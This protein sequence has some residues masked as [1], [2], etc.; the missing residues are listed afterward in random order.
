MTLSTDVYILDAVPAAE[1]FAFAA[2]LLGERPDG[3]PYEWADEVDNYWGDNPDGRRIMGRPDQG[4]PAWLTVH[5]KAGGVPLA[6]AADEAVC[7]E[8]CDV[9]GHCGH[10]HESWVT[11]NWDTAYGYSDAEGRNCTTLHAHYIVELVGWLALRGARVR[12]RNEY[13]N[14]VHDGADWKALAGFVGDGDRAQAW[15][16]T[17]AVPAILAMGG[18][19]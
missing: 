3:E 2:G 18:E 4:L 17:K 1:V 5:Y 14:E 8:D 7:T 9:D 10:A 12:W 15:F 13:T 11:V 19:V 6:T 16:Q